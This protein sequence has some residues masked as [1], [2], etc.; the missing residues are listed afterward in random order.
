[1]SNLNELKEKSIEYAKEV[2]LSYIPEDKI[3][4]LFLYGSFARNEPNSR[5]DVDIALFIKPNTLTIKQKRQ[6][7]SEAMP[8][9]IHL[10][11]VD[12]HIFDGFLS[13][14]DDTYFNAIKR[15]GKEIPLK[16]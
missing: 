3:N 6:L 15:D 8:L 7:K 4:Q 16:R 12:L 1:M 2:I 5:S 11:E 13:E 14:Y 10:P 9:D